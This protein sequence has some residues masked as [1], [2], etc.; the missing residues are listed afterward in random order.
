M[1][2]IL[3]LLAVMTAALF[4]A[5]SAQALVLQGD[6][7][8]VT[9]GKGQVTGNGIDCGADCLETV[10]WNDAEAAP[11]VLLTAAATA[12]GWAPTSYSGCNSLPSMN[13]CRVD[14]VVG[15]QKTVYVHFFDVQAP[16][17]FIAG[18]SSV[19][20]DSLHV[21]LN[22]EDNEKIT[23]VEFLLDDEVVVTQ[24]KDFGDSY[25]DTSDIPEGDHVLKVRAVDG[26]NNVGESG[27]HT[28]HVDHT[29]PE[30]VLVDPAEFVNSPEAAFTFDSPGDDY[31]YSEC[32]IR[33][34]DETVEPGACGRNQEYTAEGLTDGTWEFVVRVNDA[35]GNVRTKTHTFV[36]DLADPIVPDPDPNPEP[37]PVDPDTVDRMAP[38]VKL[39]VPKRQTLT[40]ARKALRLNVRCDEACS[41]RVVVKGKGLKF[42]G[43]VFMEK[44]GVAKL[45]L[46]PSARVRQRLGAI[47][48]RGLRGSR[49]NELKLTASANLIDKAGNPGRASLKFKVAF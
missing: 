17:V 3:I 15:Q 6:L 1:K 4:T 26:N 16:S 21:N 20:G 5:Q 7:K 22:V 29:A 47:S 43:R 10:N 9:Y 24:T 49:P 14:Y 40:T 34:Q 18:Y 19:A 13:Q 46:R 45:R 35:A 41:G 31:W 12:N 44:A 23:K 39:V 33:K 36:V 11:S 25:I 30:I 32:E 28:I 2:K 8:V 48:T 27:S 38:V 42:A 37:K